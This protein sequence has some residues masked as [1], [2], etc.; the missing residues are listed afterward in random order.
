M[1]GLLNR[2][3]PRGL[4]SCQQPQ[5]LHHTHDFKLLS[6]ACPVDSLC[7]Q[8]LKRGQ[9]PAAP[10]TGPGERASR[11]RGGP[12]LLLPV[13][14]CHPGLTSTETGGL[15]EGRTGSA[16]SNPRRCPR[17]PAFTSMAALKSFLSFRSWASLFRRVSFLFSSSSCLLC[18]SLASAS[19]RFL[20]YL[21][22]SAS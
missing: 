4:F 5:L 17:I 14:R 2:T 6:P 1:L 18:N 16:H 8:H 12:G 20:P 10:P 9:L 19:T 15:T 3:C 13:L 21:Y 22:W 11:L 7:C